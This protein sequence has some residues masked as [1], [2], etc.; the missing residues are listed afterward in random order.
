MNPLRKAVTTMKKTNGNTCSEQFSLTGCFLKKGSLIL[1][2]LLISFCYVACGSKSYNQT[3]SAVPAVT[4][5][6][7]YG[8]ADEMKS[9]SYDPNSNSAAGEASAI[10]SGSQTSSMRQQKLIKTGHVELEVEKI[11]TAYQEIDK[12]TKK[13][14]GYIF[15]MNERNDGYLK[16]LDMTTKVD[17]KHFDQI[18]ASFKD[19]GQIRS[20]SMNTQDVTREYIDVKARIETLTVQ[21]NT[22]RELLSKATKM[23]DLLQIETELQRV[24]QDIESAQGH[25]N[26]L[27]DAVS[28]S[29]IH[30][31][32][33]EK[34]LPT[35]TKKEES[36]WERF[37][38]NLQDGFGF[39]TNVLLDIIAG[40]IWLI[41]VILVFGV[42]YH[43][44]KKPFKKWQEKRA[45][46][47]KN[48]L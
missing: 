47:R 26:Y 16:H 12:L 32:L 3:E 8:S 18:M 38:F 40:I 10:S 46:Q 13:Y 48:R 17:S 1:L 5:E 41:P 9:E 28:Y 42:L 14:N 44:L 15:E 21:E 37:A 20:S 11:D 2:M 34:T 22:L 43:F 6:I 31:S 36:V 23:S 27:S 30:I 35:S 24:R 29:T 33:Q 45:E 4:E 7:D 39:W 25:L 19:I